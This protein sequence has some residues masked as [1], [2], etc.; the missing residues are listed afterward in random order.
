MAIT[1]VLFDLDGTLLPMNQDVF[2][3]AYMNGLCQTAQPHG[4]DLAMMGKTIWAGT[5]AMV[6]NDGRMLSWNA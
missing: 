1:T 3:K 5:A 2:A 6:K 4:Y